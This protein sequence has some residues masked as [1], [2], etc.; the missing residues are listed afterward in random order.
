MYRF[1]FLLFGMA[2]LVAPLA[3]ADL[4]P[5][6]ILSFDMLIPGSPSSP[7]VNTFTIAN[8]TG[9]PASGGFALPPDFSVLTSVTFLDS[10][11]TL[12]MGATS[13][14]VSLGDVAPGVFSSPDL[15]FAD[16]ALFSSA[17]FSA[18]LGETNLSL[19]GTSDTFGVDTPAIALSLLPSS[20]PSLVA[21][22]DL[23]VLNASGHLVPAPVPEPSTLPLLLTVAVALAPLLRKRLKT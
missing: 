19:S 3:H 1:V 18:T 2:S 10:T 5:I 22:T 9:D 16:S 23:L 21:G 6:G 8:F 4:E 20:G 15:E 12:F 17:L 7:G 13:Q 14:V 11:L